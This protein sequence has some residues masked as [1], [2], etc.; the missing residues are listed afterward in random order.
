MASRYFA[1]TRIKMPNQ[2]L[3]QIANQV[4]QN[5]IKA[6]HAAGSGHPGG[7]LGIADI[8]TYLYFVELN[9]DPKKPDWADRDRF[10]LSP[11]HMVPGLYSVLA[12]RGFFPES[13]LTTLR[14][15][16][17]RL[18]GHT[19]RD[20]ELGV[21]TTG[22]S[23]SQ[24]ISIAMGIALAARLQNKN[25]HTYCLISDGELNE[26]QTWEA[27][28]FA[29][30]HMLDNLVVILDRNHIQQSASTDEVMPTEPIADKF[31]AFNWQVQEIDGHDF[32]QIGFAIN[33][34]KIMKGRP[35]VIIA[36]N[37]PGK[38]VSFMENNADWHGKAPN[39]NEFEQAMK[40]LKAAI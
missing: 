23:L 24:G 35:V 2:N 27:I 31:R 4:R 11:A 5:I 28:M 14:Q 7:A 15:N 10:I 40:E 18:K 33:K 21:E 19:Y 26:G 8:L 6:V 17:S 37:T 13:E 32:G 1:Q 9:I 30:K 12:A 34:A 29:N 39:D 3:P 16:G 22:G 36:H 25:Y 20:L 38:G